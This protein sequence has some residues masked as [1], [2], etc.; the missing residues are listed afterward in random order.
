MFANGMMTRNTRI[1]LFLVAMIGFSAY[2]SFQA[3]AFASLGRDGWATAQDVRIVSGGRSSGPSQSVAVVYVDTNL[4]R[5][6]GTIR[7]PMKQPITVGESLRVRHI[8]GWS[9]WVRWHEETGRVWLIAFAIFVLIAGVTAA[10]TLDFDGAK[11]SAAVPDSDASN[12]PSAHPA[13]T[14]SGSSAD[15]SPAK[16]EDDM[17]AMLRA[18]GW[19][20]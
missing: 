6:E 15:S 11:S 16:P 8:P 3:L 1:V 2:G 18:R 4:G 20:K 14:A 9:G 12:D 7:V 13:T 5:Q 17:D 19:K 10:L